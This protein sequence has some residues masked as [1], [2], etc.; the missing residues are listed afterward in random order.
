MLDQQVDLVLDREVP[1]VASFGL[2]DME[3]HN[4]SLV[5]ASHVW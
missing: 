5:A 2:L 1:L 3:K 4:L